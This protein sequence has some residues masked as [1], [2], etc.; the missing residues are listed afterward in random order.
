[1]NKKDFEANKITAIKRIKDCNT[2]C[3]VASTK[4]DCI[5]YNC[6]LENATQM[7]L[8]SLIRS[9][10]TLSEHCWLIVEDCQKA[11][12]KEQYVKKEVEIKKKEERI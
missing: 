8:I 12:K 10:S 11:I 5:V 1:M 3:L 6:S 4:D 2:F 9:L 7:E